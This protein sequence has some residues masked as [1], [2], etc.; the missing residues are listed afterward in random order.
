MEKDLE[1]AIILL[2]KHRATNVFVKGKT[3]YVSQTRGI[4]PTLILIDHG[5]DL[6]DFTVCDRVVGKAAAMLFSL[7]KVRSVHAELISEAA[8][9]FLRSRNIKCTYEN[10]CENIINRSETDICP[11]EKATL[12]ID[13]E[14]LALEVIRKT[15]IGLRGGK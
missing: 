14:V 7:V 9:D 11:L 10:K 13:D 5:V 1:T 12:E 15:L 8:I 4:A 3:N 6:T 2:K